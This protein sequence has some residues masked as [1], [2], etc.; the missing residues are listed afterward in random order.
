MIIKTYS[1]EFPI[2]H[3]FNPDFQ[4]EL[5]FNLILV[6]GLYAANQRADCGNYR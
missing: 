5:S 1:D 3:Y 2:L 4:N 6:K